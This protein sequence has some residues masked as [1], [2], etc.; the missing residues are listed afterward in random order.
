MDKIPCGARVMIE[1]LVA[2]CLFFIEPA[3]LLNMH[4]TRGRRGGEKNAP[5]PCWTTSARQISFGTLRW[6]MDSGVCDL[7][8]LIYHNSDAKLLIDKDLRRTQ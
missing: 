7:R 8:E 1:K 6:Q 3:I 2:A 5:P 4:R